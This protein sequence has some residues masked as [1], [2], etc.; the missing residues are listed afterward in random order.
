MGSGSILDVIPKI[1]SSGQNAELGHISLMAEIK[2][3]VLAMDG[4]S[5]AG[6]DGFTGRF[7]TFAWE[8]VGQ[9]LYEAVASF[10][11]GHELP[12]SVG[13]DFDCTDS[14]GKLSLGFQSI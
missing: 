4:E 5:A 13:F 14:E 2:E 10:F 11:C 8:I 6:P 1:I 3:A 7:F 9:D 12:Q